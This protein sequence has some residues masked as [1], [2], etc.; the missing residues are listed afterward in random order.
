MLLV[1]LLGDNFMEPY[2]SRRASPQPLAAAATTTND[3]GA[4]LTY[5]WRLYFHDIRVELQR[6]APVL[7]GAMT[8][9]DINYCWYRSGLYT[10][11]YTCGTLHL[12]DFHD[13]TRTVRGA[14]FTSR[15]EVP[16]T[17]RG[18]RD[19]CD[20]PREFF[21]L[22]YAWEPHRRT[23]TYRIVLGHPVITFDGKSLLNIYCY[24]FSPAA[25]QAS[26]GIFGKKARNAAEEAPAE[27]SAPL[28]CCVWQGRDRGA[29]PQGMR[30]VP[31]TIF[32]ESRTLAGLPTQYPHVP[33]SIG[34]AVLILTAAVLHHCHP[35]ISGS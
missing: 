33:I 28:V 20:G 15:P 3:G 16:S 6:E 9:L 7:L 27:R 17:P 35:F 29:M 10:M 32:Q 31:R 13:G 2:T 14:V 5:G 12:Q 1:A 21:T 8:G 4:V 34:Q 26:R 25:A 18:R 30:H 19:S 23:C 11:A 24:I 22:Q